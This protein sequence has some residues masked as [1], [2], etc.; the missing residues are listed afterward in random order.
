MSLS[1]SL[2]MYY[3]ILIKIIY[4]KNNILFDAGTWLI[5]LVQNKLEKVYTLYFII[6][7]FNLITNNNNDS[8]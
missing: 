4:Y 6:Y 2:D 8:I 3:I 1:D 5:V 7:K